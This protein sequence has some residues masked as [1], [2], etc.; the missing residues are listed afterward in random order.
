[1]A[2]YT[3]PGH[4]VRLALIAGLAAPLCLLRSDL[5]RLQPRDLGTLAA[6]CG[7]RNL[8][9]FEETPLSQTGLGHSSTLRPGRTGWTAGRAS[10]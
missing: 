6:V 4:S 7:Q 3:P 8:R 1:M 9:P 10:L 5:V 2:R